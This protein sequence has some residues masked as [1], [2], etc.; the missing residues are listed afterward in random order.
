MNKPPQ[1][2]SQPASLIL[3]HRKRLLISQKEC[4]ERQKRRAFSSYIRFRVV[5]A[6]HQKRASLTL[7]AAVLGGHASQLVALHAALGHVHLPAL[8][9]PR[10][11]FIHF[12]MGIS[13]ER[14]RGG[15]RRERNLRKSKKMPVWTPVAQPYVNAN[16]SIPPFPFSQEQYAMDG[17]QI[18]Y[19]VPPPKEA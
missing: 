11:C 1:L 19:L 8:K 16:P 7:R 15:K 3:L 12:V 14:R 9:T 5:P 10:S 17:C 4:K 13:G 6:K 2:A 18:F